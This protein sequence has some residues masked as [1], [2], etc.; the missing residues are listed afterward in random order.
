[1]HNVDRRN[2]NYILVASP[3]TLRFCRLIVKVVGIIE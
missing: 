2:L 3:I 1:M